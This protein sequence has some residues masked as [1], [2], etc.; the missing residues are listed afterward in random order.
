M[1]TASSSTPLGATATKEDA[2]LRTSLE[3]AVNE[4]SDTRPSSKKPLQPIVGAEDVIEGPSGGFQ[5][6]ENFHTAEPQ[7]PTVVQQ[8]E[9]PASIAAHGFTARD[10]DPATVYSSHQANKNMYRDLPSDLPLDL[11]F[12]ADPKLI[13]YGNLLRLATKFS[14]TEIRRRANEGR[15]EEVFKSSQTVDSRVRAAIKSAADTW[16]PGWTVDVVEAWLDRERTSNGLMVRTKKRARVEGPAVLA[17]GG[18]EGFQPMA[19]P[20]RARKDATSPTP[21]PATPHKQLGSPQVG[22]ELYHHPWTPGSANGYA[23]DAGEETEAGLTNLLSPIPAAPGLS[24]HRSEYP[25][26]AEIA[27]MALRDVEE[28]KSELHPG[29]EQ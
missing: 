24:T 19:T 4:P 17:P 26:L 21:P 2:A 6:P 25:T 3:P 10:F 1:Q 7:H 20:K 5:H 29:Q 12:R 13:A 9:L 11:I 16:G 23:Q 14:N 15:P 18:E 22:G 27:D 28:G 8:P